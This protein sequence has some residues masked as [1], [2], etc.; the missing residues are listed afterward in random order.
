MQFN[1]VFIATAL[2]ASASLVM[3]STSFT[4]FAGADCTGTVET[5]NTNVGSN[6][7]YTDGSNSAKS[8]SYSGVKS[9]IQFFVSGGG[10]D[11]C[12]NGPSLTLGGGSG[13][14]TAPAGFNWE[15]VF[16]I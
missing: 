3:A 4:S 10:H 12:S 5:V 9:E 6:V 8:I 2:L 1:V 7:C 14:A 13:C 15:S 11:N 16:I